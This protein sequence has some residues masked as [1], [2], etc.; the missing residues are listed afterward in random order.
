MTVRL[1]GTGAAEGIPAFVSDSRVSNYAREHGGRD[2]RTRCGA[3]ID[4]SI[5]IDL[6]PDT[7]CHIHRDRLDARDWTCLIFTHSHADHFAIE[8]IQYCLYPFSKLEFLC[9][10]IYGNEHVCAMIGEKYPSWPLD[11]V[12]VRTFEPFTHE[13]YTITPIRA[14]HQDDEESLNYIFERNGKTLLYATDTGIWPE[15]TWEYLSRFRLDGLVIECTEGLAS[16]DFHGHLSAA[17]V[18]EVVSRLR[19]TG[20]ISEKTFIT[21]THHSHNG[22]ATHSELEAALNPHGIQV[23]FDGMEFQI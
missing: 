20:V 3:L 17:E 2:V 13:E 5:K 18:L 19:K 16:T 1:L 6:P 8:E 15:E 21:T 11:V 9:W 22:E 23:G 4:G 14:T 10:T 7:L 12:S